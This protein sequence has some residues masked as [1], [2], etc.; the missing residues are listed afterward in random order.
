MDSTQGG[1][2]ERV[3]IVGMGN[4]G[5]AIASR[6]AQTFPVIGTDLAEDRQEAARTQ[7]I[8]V[9][10]L[11]RIAEV[12][13]TV[14]LSL[15]HP[16]ASLDV[17]RRLAQRPGS[18]SCVVE[19]STVTPAHLR[20]LRGVLDSVDVRLVEAAI[21]S[22]VAPMQRGEAGLALAGDPADLALLQPLFDAIT[23]NQ[24]VVGSAGSAMAAK[25]INNAVAHVVM[26]LL[27]ECTSLAYAAGV[28]MDVL[29][30]L[31]KSPEGGLMRPLTHRL[32]E[33]VL[34]NDY[35][36]GM[37]LEAARK[38]SALVQELAQDL[39]VPLFTIPIAHSVYEIAMAQGWKREDYSSLVRL[40][41]LWGNVSFRD[42]HR[43][44]G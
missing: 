33:R 6:L 20:E 42:A 30:D 44:V 34:R 17:G 14:V 37:S 11:E 22:G 8:E 18:V 40:W 38:D 12:C 7:G 10:D 32:V 27:G 16:Q 23:V 15:P 4:M 28:K 35:E 25:V 36:G 9:V 26:V 19:C 5:L 13:D 31:L 29:I 43:E 24:R 41:E 39:N 1:G 3:G 21:L 2:P